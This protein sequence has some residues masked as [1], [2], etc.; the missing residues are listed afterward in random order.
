MAS[1]VKTQVVENTYG[2][3]TRPRIS[4][5]FGFSMGITIAAAPIVLIFVISLAMGQIIFGLV[6]FVVGL[7]LL[8]L[9]K[10]TVRQG[11]SVY[12]RIMLRLVQRRKVAAKEHLYLSGPA[13]F[14]PTGDARLPGLLAKSELSSH[15]TSFGSKFGMIRLSSRG[16][17]HYSVVLSAYPDGR[18]VHDQE[19]Y[20]NRVAHFAGWLTQRG[21]DEGLIGASVTVDTSPDSGLRLPAMMQDRR[22]AA[23][24]NMNYTPSTYTQETVKEIE[25]A[26]NIGS[27]QLSAYV[28]LTFDGSTA[29]GKNRDRGLAE[30]AEEIGSKLPGIMSE[31]TLA[32][33]GTVQPCT[34]QEIVD[35][36]RGAYDP[37]TAAAIESAQAEGG[38][39]LRWEDAGPS[40]AVDAFEYYRHDRAFSKSWTMYEGPTG[41]FTSD[42]LNRVTQPSPRA[43]RKRLTM[44][45]R[46][47]PR[48]ETT[49]QVEREQKD[50]LFAG[51]QTRVSARAGQRLANARKSA[52]EEARGSGLTRFGVIVTVTVDSVEK[53]REFDRSVPGM[54]TQAKLRMRPALANQA[55][56]F[57]AGL[58]LGLVVPAHMVVPDELRAWF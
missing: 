35:Y 5:L 34:A 36:T 32:G 47:I 10:F 51:S 26:S 44:L 58:P 4:G 16:N 54:L 41:V 45:Y 3:L 29:E 9:T 8:A 14:T 39:G 33:A 31:L 12:G 15:S 49:A 37:T 38:T 55:V 13:G 52:E 18:S 30:M 21:D 53:L 24:N 42:S 43:L 17:H 40:F 7:V 22:D 28:T 1:S 46:P 20:E 48:E 2:N 56:T 6:V 27:P 57:Q 23:Q 50:A 25:D 11:R 19:Q